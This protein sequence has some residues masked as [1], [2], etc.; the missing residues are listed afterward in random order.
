MQWSKGAAQ[1]P[2][3]SR[4][5]RGEP[6]SAPSQQGGGVQEK[7]MGRS[8]SSRGRQRGFGHPLPRQEIGLERSVVESSQ[9]PPG[10][11]SAA[12]FPKWT[13]SSGTSVE[14]PHGPRE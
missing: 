2:E 3:G 6:N 11:L 13:R 4:W 5:G 9:A 14:P 10:L 12:S 1:G 7:G 8:S